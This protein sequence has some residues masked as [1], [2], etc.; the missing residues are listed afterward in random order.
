MPNSSI[1]LR[2]TVHELRHRSVNLM[3]TSPKKSLHPSARFVLLVLLHYC[4]D[5]GLC[6]PAQA[7]IESITGYGTTAVRDALN[8]LVRAG[9]IEVHSVDDMQI[10][11]CRKRQGKVYKITPDAAA[12]SGL[13]LTER[14]GDPSLSEGEHLGEHQT[15]TR[16]E[17]E[18]DRSPSH[19]PDLRTP[20]LEVTRASEHAQPAG[21]GAQTRHDGDGWSGSLPLDL[22]DLDDQEHEALLWRE[23]QAM[24]LAAADPDR[25]SAYV[26]PPP[27][28]PM[29]L[30][31][32]AQD[33]TPDAD[34][35]P[36]EDRHAS[37]DHALQEG[38]EA[39]GVQDVEPR[40]M[41]AEDAAAI[42]AEL[43]REA[44]ERAAQMPRLKTRE[45]LEAEWAEDRRIRD[46]GMAKLLPK[47]QAMWTLTP[48]E[49]AARD[50]QKRLEAER[51][52]AARAELEA[53][54]SI[55]EVDGPMSGADIDRLSGHV[56]RAF[57]ELARDLEQPEIAPTGVPLLIKR[58]R[59]NGLQTRAQWREWWDWVQRELARHCAAHETPPTPRQILAWVI[60][61]QHDYLRPQREAKHVREELAHQRRAAAQ[62]GDSSEV[63]P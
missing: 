16:R 59:S 5:A 9:A 27:H 38:G 24:C 44:L 30:R 4:D 46:E 7:T 31:P 55:S 12:L 43:E 6:W 37:P 25:Q 14:G 15:R 35:A 13:P 58:A 48:E 21:A 3:R 51:E 18:P 54:M 53:R 34:S 20:T 56:Q 32:T 60:A 1:A 26:A 50:E 10:D 41:S 8:A 36:Q 47:L 22:D 40:V 29:M 42:A 49:Q 28:V 17:R 39:S 61:D 63:A 2:G 62:T 11:R 45:E 52:A 33:A 19:A 23:Y 57:D